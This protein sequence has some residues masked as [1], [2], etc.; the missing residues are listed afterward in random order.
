MHGRWRARSHPTLQY[1]RRH[2]VVRLSPKLLRRRLRQ[3]SAHARVQ[4]GN[5][6][7]PHLLHAGLHS[8]AVVRRHAVR[9]GLESENVGARDVLG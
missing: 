9:D 5:V 8:S 7:Q 1:L 2:D 6:L 4:R 3:K